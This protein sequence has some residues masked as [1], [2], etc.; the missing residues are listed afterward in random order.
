MAILIDIF[1]IASIFI[2][3]YLGWSAGLTRSFFAVF[4]G[5]LSIF[6]ASKYPYQEGINFWLIFVITVLAVMLVSGFVLRLVNFFYMNIADKTGGAVLSALVWIVVAVNVLVP[7]LTHGTHALDGSAR[8]TV[9]KTISNKMHK[10][11][12]IFKDYVPPA[13]ERKALERQREAE[14]K[15]IGG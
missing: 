5:F 7:T 9:Y 11:I 14:D 4:A 2:I 13:L 12:S 8:N 10:H 6:A 3:G 15:K 1:L